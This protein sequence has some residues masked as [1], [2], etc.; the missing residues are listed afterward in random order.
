[1]LKQF[2]FWTLLLIGTTVPAVAQ[3]N[4]RLD[5]LLSQAP[6]R[7]DSTSYLLMTA[8]GLIEEDADPI[9]AYEAAVKA[10]FIA[11]KVAPDA[12]VSVEV[13]SF[14]VMKALKLPGGVGWM[15]FP[16]PRA[17]YRELAYHDIINTSSGP[18]RLV[19]GDE[20]IRTF[21]AAAAL[22]GGEE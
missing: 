1:M 16:G 11:N 6:A 2:V 15:L 20:V 4:Q 18:E 5:E 10:G 8:A 17:A 14:L 12:P 7:L 13:L 19:A 22:K 3:S 21:N 9:T